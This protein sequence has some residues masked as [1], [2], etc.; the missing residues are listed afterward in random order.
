MKFE[1]QGH[2][3]YRGTAERWYES[4]TAMA[5]GETL[6]TEEAKKIESAYQVW[7]KGYNVKWRKTVEAMKA[8]QQNTEWD[9]LAYLDEC[10]RLELA[11][12]RRDGFGDGKPYP[13]GDIEPNDAY[14]ET[15]A[16]TPG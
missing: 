14:Y 11:A 6:S 16:N 3:Y 4:Y 2:T 9:Y 10:E 15:G 7:L 13:A 12:D 8:L 1:F 5:K